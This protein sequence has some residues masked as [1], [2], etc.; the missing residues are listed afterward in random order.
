MNA[1]LP[2]PTP[3]HLHATQRRYMSAPELAVLETALPE[4]MTEDMRA[5]AVCMFEAVVLMDG[6]CGQAAPAGEWLA[7]LQA[8]AVQ[9]MAQ[10]QH[11]A[12]EVGGTAI[13]FA[14]GLAMHISTRDRELYAR[15]NGHN[16]RELAKLYDITETRVRQIIAAIERERFL[17]RQGKL[18]GFDDD[19][20]GGGS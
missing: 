16:H 20:D 14:K 9:V 6:R 1:P 3:A 18:A 5:V 10:M 19:D 17:Q 7:Q 8:W 2:M 13:Y 15:F 11:I 12:A 4:K